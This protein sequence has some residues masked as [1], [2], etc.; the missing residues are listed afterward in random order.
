MKH[1]HPAALRGFDSYEVRLGDEL[2]GQRAT[3][4]RSLLD[5][6]RDL[7]I[8]AAYIDA[9][10]NCDASVIPNQGFV[11][12]YVRA[13]ARYLGLDGDAI[14]ARFCAESGFSTFAA[15]RG[16]G[17]AA[18]RRSPRDPALARSHFAAPVG[19][20]RPVGFGVSASDI[21]SVAVLG[22]LVAG[23]GWGG[24][25]VLRDIQRVDF[26]PLETAPG[27]MVD[28]PASVLAPGLALQAAPAPTWAES[29][30]DRDEVLTAL[31]APPEAPPPAIEMRD[32]PIAGIDPDAIG[33][34]PP[35]ARRDA[36]PDLAV[37][38]APPAPDVAATAA[39]PQDAPIL[40]AG[41][42]PGLPALAASAPAG[43]P[44][45]EGLWLV[46]TEPCWIQVRSGDGVTLVERIFEAGERWRVPDGAG[47]PRLRVGNAGGVLVEA[48]G[49]RFGPLGRSG[50]VLRAV[51]LDPVSVAETFA[52]LR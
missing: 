5:V 25:A 28:A 17:A 14:Y 42:P 26:A 46:F 41:L 15:A 23:L 24:W 10:E 44:E 43:D 51:S 34:Y 29:S 9:I 45:A 12:G 36:P 11:P 2:R 31:Y 47:S 22:L 38:A 21:G 49:R 8:K 13:Y 39:A 33:L 30:P 37:A 50:E 1:D 19:R 48:D 6:Q 20:A 7:R 4:G 27:A 52:E 18:T 16:G 35:T 32:G 40:T 3:L